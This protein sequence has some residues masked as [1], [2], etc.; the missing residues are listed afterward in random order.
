MAHTSRKG[1]VLLIKWLQSLLDDIR[2]SRKRK[3]TIQKTYPSFKRKKD[4]SVIAPMGSEQNEKEKA[5]EKGRA[6]GPLPRQSE[7]DDPHEGSKVLR[8]S[9]EGPC[10]L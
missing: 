1:G 9:V 2:D 4:V 7:K 5:K 6:K 10:M 3:E 8:T